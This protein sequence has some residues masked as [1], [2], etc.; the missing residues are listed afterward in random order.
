MAFWGTL[1]VVLATMTFL[2][3]AAEPIDA[4]VLPGEVDSAASSGVIPGYVPADARLPGAPSAPPVGLSIPTKGMSAPVVPAG[5]DPQ[6]GLAIPADVSRVGW[7]VGGAEPGDPTGTV[8]LAGHVDDVWAGPGALFGLAGTPLGVDVE[9]D[10]ALG[11]HR[12]RTVA[13]RSYPKSALPAQLFSSQGPRQL[14]LVTCGG[15]F[16][17]GQYADNVVVYAEYVGRAE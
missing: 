4:G 17:S 2:G 10:T 3:T 16:A 7:W 12:Y 14:A 13:R 5:V 1:A 15:R 9:I 11:R 8:L 6:G